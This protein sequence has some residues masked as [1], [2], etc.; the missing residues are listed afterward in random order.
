M[1]DSFGNRMKQYEAVSSPILPPNSCVF[2]RVD[3]KAFHSFTKKEGC[4]RPFDTKLSEAMRYAM[5]KTAQEMQGFKLAY[6]QSDEVT[7]LLTDLDSPQ[8]QPWFNNEV[9]KL[10]SITASMFTAFF[11][12]RYCPKYDWG[13]FDA[14]AFAVPERDAPNVMVWRQKDYFRNSLSMLA[15]SYFPHKELMGKKQADL[16]QMLHNKGI[17]WAD[18]AS[19]KRNGSWWDGYSFSHDVKTYYDIEKFLTG[20]DSM[21][22]TM[23][24]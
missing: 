7:F 15:Q 3:G 17:S 5:R 12:S 4:I 11:N 18:L 16:Y 1:K 9:N 23:L 20:V 10:V 14:R 19:W 24:D 2:I 22:A 21:E 6:T 8:S 13:F